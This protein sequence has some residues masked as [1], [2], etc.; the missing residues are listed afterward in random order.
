[1]SSS[2]YRF[3]VS[4]SLKKPVQLLIL[5]FRASCI[6]KYLRKKTFQTARLAQEFLN[7][8]LNPKSNIIRA[9]TTQK[10]NLCKANLKQSR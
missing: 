9:L 2:G 1:M 8:Q 4:I 10:Q 7:T 3:L 6:F 5:P